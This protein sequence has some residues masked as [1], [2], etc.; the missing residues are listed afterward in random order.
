MSGNPGPEHKPNG[1]P[2]RLLLSL[3]KWG[4]SSKEDAKRKA[5]AMSKSWEVVSKVFPQP[6]ILRQ[7]SRKVRVMVHYEYSPT[8]WGIVHPRDGQRVAHK[9]DITFVKR[10]QT[11]PVNPTKPVQLDLFGSP[12]Q[13]SME[14]DVPMSQSRFGGTSN[15]G[16]SF[17]EIEKAKKRQK[18]KLNPQQKIF[19]DLARMEAEHG[20]A[21][22]NG[23][24]T[25]PR[26]VAAIARG[27]QTPGGVD[28]AVANMNREY[29]KHQRFAR[30]AK[31]AGVAAVGAGLIGA[32]AYGLHRRNRLS[33]VTKASP[34]AGRVL[35]G[36]SDAVRSASQSGTRSGQTSGEILGRIRDSAA[37]DAR[38]QEMFGPR[39]GAALREVAPSRVR[40]RVA[41]P[42]GQGGTHARITSH[43]EIAEM[44]RQQSMKG[45]ELVLARKPGELVS[46]RPVAPKPKKTGTDLVRV[47]SPAGAAGAPRTTGSSLVPVRTAPPVQAPNYGKEMNYMPHAAVAA[48]IGSYGGYKVS[49]RL[50]EINK[51]YD[52]YGNPVKSGMASG[53]GSTALGLAGAGTAAYGVKTMR[54]AGALPRTAPIAEKVAEAANNTAIANSNAARN[55]VALNQAKLNAAKVKRPVFNGSRAARR[56]LVESQRQS[57]MVDRQ[58][59][60]T[61][62]KL[63]GT[64]AALADIPHAMKASRNFGAAAVLGGTA[65]TAGVL[66]NKMRGS[67]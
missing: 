9:D 8:H 27:H 53:S 14:Y 31:I 37:K 61:A 57:H 29:L 6:A 47:G 48:G 64:Q 62:G 26:K 33:D 34:G 7:G 35:Q 15:V 56:T 45:K 18:P 30:G 21:T 58:A 13:K 20:E 43:D 23:H 24:G 41:M 65:L 19:R 63:A 66:H 55:T 50:S 28:S 32:T 16:Y 46:T 51:A 36:A 42:G 67:N 44:M 2:T 3:Q 38:R 12:I 22:A 25:A 52:E 54:N 10:K 60:K 11:K 4:A 39:R 17:E 40:T 49:K 1:E 5:A 59:Q